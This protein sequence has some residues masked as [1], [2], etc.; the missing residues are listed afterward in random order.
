[1]NAIRNETD[2]R[3][4]RSNTHTKYRKIKKKEEEKTQAPEDPVP[5]PCVWHERLV[6]R[7]AH[8]LH[9]FPNVVFFC[10]FARGSVPSPCVF[11]FLLSLSFSDR[12]PFSVVEWFAAKVLEGERF[13]R[14]IDMYRRGQIMMVECEK[15]I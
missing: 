15:K 13:Y 10:V 8:V 2:N 11:F 14:H 5:V 9:G 12:Q 6:I 4:D 3:T 1:M 7:Y